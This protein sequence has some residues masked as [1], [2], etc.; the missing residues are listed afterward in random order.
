DD[1]GRHRADG[2]GAIGHIND[3]HA[4]QKTIGHRLL[5]KM[6]G[7]H[8]AGPR[9]PLPPVGFPGRQAGGRLVGV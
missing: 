3:L 1:A 4:M 2:A 6:S 5:G 8:D 7:P 9:R